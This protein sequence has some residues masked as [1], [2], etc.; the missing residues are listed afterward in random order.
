MEHVE[1]ETDI[2]LL[3]QYS[4]RRMIAQGLN[5]NQ[6][7]KELTA[8]NVSVCG[9]NNPSSGANQTQASPFLSM[10]EIKRDGEQS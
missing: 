9:L 4:E 8:L 2:E 10:C 3:H 1:E 7:L 5:S 6:D